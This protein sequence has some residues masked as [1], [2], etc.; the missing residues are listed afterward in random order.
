M[1]FKVTKVIDGDTFEVL[2]DW[3]WNNQ[4]GNVIRANGYNT[5]EQGQA[6][7]QAAKD[8]LTSLI[9]GKE[10]EIKNA[11]KFTY[12]RLL[13]DVFYK[14]TSLADYFSEYQ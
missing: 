7:Y 1:S 14:G 8:K 13:C 4:E 5:P 6:G 12:G 10:V 9:L 3:K 2:P 11:I